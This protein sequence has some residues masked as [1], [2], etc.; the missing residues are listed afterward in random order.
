MSEV[1]DAMAAVLSALPDD[2]F[3]INEPSLT[4]AIPPGKHGV[5]YYVAQA[6]PAVL[7]RFRDVTWDLALISPITSMQAAG[8]P[9]FDALMALLD[10]LEDDQTVRWTS[11]AL[12]PFGDTM[13]CYSLQI[14]MYTEKTEE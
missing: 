10:V 4:P 7:D 8:E 11:A 14:T 6:T 13:W 3:V 5:M 1:Y 12:E 2:E 9:L